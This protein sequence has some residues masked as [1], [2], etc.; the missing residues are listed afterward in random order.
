MQKVVSIRIL[1]FTT[2]LLFALAAVAV[3][4]C[5]SESTGS[6]GS[7]DDGSGLNAD[8]VAAPADAAPN[9][10]GVDA[11]SQPLPD[12][13]DRKIV[14][15]ATLELSVENV[16]AAVQEIEN[17]AVA[18]SG[19]VSG[20]SVFVESQPEEDTGVTPR[21]TQTGT[22]TIRVPADAYPS[23]MTQLRALSKEVL[24]E[25]SDA[26][27]VT[28]EYTDLQ[29]RIRNLEATENQY[30][31]LLKKAEQI[32]DILTVQDRLNQVRGE[33]EQAKGRLQVLDDL[34]AL[35]TI[36]VR[37][38]LPPASVE[39]KSN[40]GWAAGAVEDS[41]ETSKDAAV[42]FGTAG[43]FGAVLMA[44][45]TVPCLLLWIAWR[46]FGRRLVDVAN[47]LNKA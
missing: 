6:L 31:E 15:S 24:A 7:S 39:A 9:A 45:L 42:I 19:F 44:W 3:S 8:R 21:R 16:G 46:T 41:W 32:P 14:R 13:A 29:A 5:G 17:I 26:S 43:I 11:D 18:G 23:I 12:V 28:E 22:V 33:I 20:S 2:I 25:T 38:S 47:R 4:A 40:Q 34:T 27:E 10:E 37:L 35:A 1:K 30:L 36:T